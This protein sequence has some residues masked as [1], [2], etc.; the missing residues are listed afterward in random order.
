MATATTP[1]VLIGAIATLF[2]VPGDK[3]GHP[4]AIT[5]DNGGAAKHTI[6]FRDDFTPDI[7]N[8]VPIPVAQ[9]I[10][11]GQYEVGAG[12]TAVISGDD[13]KGKDIIGALKCYADAADPLCITTCDYDFDDDEDY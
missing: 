11:K 12:L 7:S 4:R 8:A 13:L 1:A 3:K 9:T 5:I 2:T 10:A 6:Y